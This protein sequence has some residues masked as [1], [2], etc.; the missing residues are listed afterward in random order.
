MVAEVLAKA[1]RIVPDEYDRRAR[2][3]PAFLALVPVAAVAFGCYQLELK[4]NT[5]FVG[6]VSYFGVFFL[7]LNISRELGK[8]HEKRLYEKWGGQPTTQLLRHSNAVI[9]RVTKDRY[10]RYLEAALGQSFPTPAEEAASP[11]AADQIYAG[12]VR[13]LL[14]KTRDKKMFRMLFEENIAYGFRRNGYGIRW[15]AIATS[16]AS[17]LWILCVAQIVTLTGFDL[18]RVL[19]MNTGQIVALVISVAAIPVWAKFFTE[20]TI[21]TASFTYADILLRSCDLLP[22]KRKVSAKP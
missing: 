11:E 4:L 8:R 9:D 10:H 2:L 21:Q 22:K 19:G 1:A 18:Q 15:I 14:S 17:I 6:L 13:Y 16:L 12:A 20:Q 5:A 7:F 3:F